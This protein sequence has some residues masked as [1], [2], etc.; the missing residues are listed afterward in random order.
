MNN[1]TN[2]A[3]G[4]PVIAA[5]DNLTI[6]GN[7]DTI[8]RS[9]ATAAYFRLLDVAS[10]GSLTLQNLTL[11]GG[12][13]VGLAL[14]RR[15]RGHLQPGHAGPERRDRSGQHGR[16]PRYFGSGMDA[17]YGG[18]IFSYGGSVTLEGGTIVRNNGAWRPR[19]SG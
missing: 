3:T 19:S 12:L 6:V 11:Q 9:T 16:G 17:A 10:G 18:G 7:G 8:E 2:G 1:T 13:G 4:L 14:K 5:N 15:R